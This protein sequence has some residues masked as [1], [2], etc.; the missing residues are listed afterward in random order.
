[1]NWDCGSATDQEL[2]RTLLQQASA[3]RP[4]PAAGGRRADA[5]NAWSQQGETKEGPGWGRLP[6]A[7]FP[8][9]SPLGTLAAL[10]VEPESCYKQTRY[11]RVGS[12]QY[13]DRCLRLNRH[14]SMMPR[15]E[16]KRKQRMKEADWLIPLVTSAT[17]PYC[18]IQRVFITEW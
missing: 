2:M 13:L 1:M 15:E 11:V 18:F 17:R 6:A 4:E 16:I 10:I 3:T 12:W 8:R 5:A 7:V 9:S 14:K